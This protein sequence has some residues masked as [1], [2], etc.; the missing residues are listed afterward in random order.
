M[1]RRASA[2]SL[3]A[4]LFVG[5]TVTHHARRPQTL[6]QLDPIV[7]KKRS[8]VTLLYER[9]DGAKSPV[10]PS[11]PAPAESPRE[12]GEG[13]PR[14]EVSNLRGYEVM[15]R[16]RG[17]LEGLGIGI[18]VGALS[19]YAVGAS[20]GS[21]GPCTND[22]GGCVMFSGA[23]KGLFFGALFAVAGMALGP[24]I[25]MLVGHTDRTVFSSGGGE[26]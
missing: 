15:H 18:L 11:L 1:K 19:G 14:L 26:P 22:D 21:D 7:W 10:P 9:P 2:L 12:G 25:G 6:E 4:T 3:A 23:D 20:Q 17:A 8:Y 5:C 24:L 13:A 16:G